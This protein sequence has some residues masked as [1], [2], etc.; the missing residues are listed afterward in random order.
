MCIFDHKNVMDS[1]SIKKYPQFAQ[2]FQTEEFTKRGWFSGPPL[3]HL[4]SRIVVDT[5]SMRLFYQHFLVV[6][7]QAYDIVNPQSL[8]QNMGCVC[9][10]AKKFRKIIQKLE[11]GRPDYTKKASIDKI[12]K[13]ASKKNLKFVHK[14]AK[15]LSK[16]KIKGLPEFM[17]QQSSE[18]KD[19]TAVTK[20]VPKPVA[21]QPIAINVTSAPVAQP[22]AAAA[23]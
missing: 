2:L 20:P 4:K 17:K 10:D 5:N 12:P 13:F 23:R 7:K 19:G 16:L 15:A 11:K 1:A 6:L 14:M 18:Y 22:A 3:K 21:Q 8:K 9:K